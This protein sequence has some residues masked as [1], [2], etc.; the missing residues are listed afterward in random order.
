MFAFALSEV[1]TSAVSVLGSLYPVT[2]VMLAAMLLKER[3]APL[4]AA[5]VT[6]VIAGIALVGAHA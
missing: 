3:L 5:G 4:Q 6:A 1:L 2:T